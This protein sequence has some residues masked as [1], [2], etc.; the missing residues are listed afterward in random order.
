MPSRD[1][2]S[3]LLQARKLTLNQTHRVSKHEILRKRQL[4]IEEEIR[5]SQLIREQSKTAREKKFQKSKLEEMKEKK[6]ESR[7]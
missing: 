6:S 7:L 2:N 3:K 4:E 1:L 5:I